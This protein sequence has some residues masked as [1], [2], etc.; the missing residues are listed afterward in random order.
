MDPRLERLLKT[1]VDEYIATA[2]PIG[3]QHLVDRYHL[4]VSPATIRNWFAELEEAGWLMQPHTS[5]GRIPTE[6]G[7]QCYVDRFVE[8]HK[9]ALKRD[10][11]I[12]EQAAL[13]PAEEGRRLKTMAKA[14]AEC[15]GLAAFVGLS[16]GDTFYTGLSQLFAQPEFQNWQTVVSLSEV[17]DRLDETLH[18]LRATSYTEPKLFLGSACPFGR[19]CSSLLVSIQGDVI[20]LLGPVRMDYQAT[21]SLLSSALTFLQHP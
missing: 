10:R 7:F 8:P 9:P 5:G 19:G 16:Q 15:S 12:L 20:G 1:V 11:D 3:S 17:L 14:L 13:A 6:L 2:E 21:R 18:V 4:D